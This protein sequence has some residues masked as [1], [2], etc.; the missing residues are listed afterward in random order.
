MDWENSGVSG[1][2]SNS[3]VPDENLQ[4]LRITGPDSVPIKR[5]SLENLTFSELKSQSEGFRGI[6]SVWA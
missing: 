1:C 6:L 4:S 3:I 5:E 2:I